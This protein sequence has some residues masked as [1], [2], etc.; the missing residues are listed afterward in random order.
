MSS[1]TY[2]VTGASRGIGFAVSSML[3][4]R[5]HRVIGLARHA[6]GVDFPGEL[7]ACDLADIDQT[8]ATLA[9]IGASA[10]IDGIVNNA[11]IALPQPL[12]Q[13]DFGSLQAVFDLNVR[14]AIQVTQHF[15]DAMK[16][17]GHGR[18][19][20]I[21]SRAIFGSLDRTAYSAAKSA[22]V[23]CTRTWALEL[24]EHGVTVNAVAPGPIETE[25]F[26]Q[27]RPVGSEAER[28]VLATIP[29]RRLG[30]PDDVAAA[31]AFFL[32]DEAGFVTGQV[33]AVD[34]GGSLG[35]RG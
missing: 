9:R 10:D 21:C 11:G 14:A 2:L 28:K 27:T 33:L 20:N 25:L 5:G 16:A 6:Q 31:I 32:S 22:L 13:I 35:G 8:A 26:R 17:R 1:R 3:A 12:G 15:A 24:A 34:G 29:A 7:L 23:G 19:V 18:I 4:R 30:T